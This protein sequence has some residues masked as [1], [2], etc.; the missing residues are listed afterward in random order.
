MKLF[1]VGYYGYHNIGDEEI[2][3]GLITY[4]R[5]HLHYPRISVLSAFP[6]HTTRQY[7]VISVGRNE[8][9]KI[10]RTIKATDVVI[11]GGGSLLQDVTGQGL[12]A[13]YY[14]SFILLA[15]FFRK[16]TILLAQGIG[17]ITKPIVR[18]IMS[19]ILS[20]VDYI[21]VREN[22]SR[23]FLR[24][25]GVRGKIN[26]IP[27]PVILNEVQPAAVKERQYLGISLR[28]GFF[29]D[30]PALAEQLDRVIHSLNMKIVFFS[31]QSGADDAV[32]EKVRLLM[33]HAAHTEVCGADRP[34][35]E[36]VERIGG[37][38]VFAGTRL[39]SLVYAAKKHIPFLGLNYDPK[40][41]AFCKTL[42][43]PYLN[44]YEVGYLTESIQSL[45]E[46]KDPLL[47]VLKRK[48]MVW[49]KQ[50]ARG[51]EKCIAYLDPQLDRRIIK[52][53]RGKSR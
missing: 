4:F 22:E 8:R 49:E 48:L 51:M 52:K 42:G 40:I 26:L 17:P 5:A 20:R 25:L 53:S 43:M 9:R 11:L 15:K 2:L 6:E 31:F 34:V 50:A 37:C 32:I 47:K 16:K 45:W 46:R 44:L 19:W 3:R 14:L 1:L 10:V 30:V 38:Q 41:G 12:S 28:P 35:E 29:R 33:T 36:I 21:S 24:R 7:N 39:H 27:D 18:L 13:F 23:R